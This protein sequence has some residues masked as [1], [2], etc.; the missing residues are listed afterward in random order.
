MV[1]S[2]SLRPRRSLP[3]NGSQKDVANCFA[4]M[5]PDSESVGVCSVKMATKT[6][7]DWRIPFLNYREQYRLPDNLAQKI[8][9]KKRAT[10][11]VVL[12]DILYRHTLD[13]IFRCTANH[14]IHEVVSEVLSIICGPYQSGPK[15]YMPIRR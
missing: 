2:F 9:S 6:I 10:E 8:E 15:L 13:G 1:S 7:K 12:K 3:Y 11:F 5:L 14:E 4:E